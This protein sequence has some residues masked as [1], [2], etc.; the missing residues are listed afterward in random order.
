M[1]ENPYIE[2]ARLKGDIAGCY[3]IKLRASSFRLIYQVINSEVVILVI[4]VGKCEESK[5]Y[6]LAEVRIQKNNMY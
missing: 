5:A 2:S 3:K 4:A 1:Q 6:S